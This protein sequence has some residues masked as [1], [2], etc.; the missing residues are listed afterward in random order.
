MQQWL[1][2]ATGRRRWVSGGTGERTGAERGVQVDE[3]GRDGRNGTG[4][5][6]RSE[7]E[8]KVSMRSS[9]GERRRRH[10]GR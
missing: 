2:V 9:S 4:L 1:Q 6:M 10:D 8:P 7:A 5:P 3:I